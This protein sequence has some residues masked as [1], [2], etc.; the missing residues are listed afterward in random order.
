MKK[1]IFRTTALLLLLS[2]SIFAQ[3]KKVSFGLKGG[4]NYSNL[5]GGDNKPIVG[6]HVGGFTEIKLSNLISFQPELLFSAQGFKLETPI[7]ENFD[8]PITIRTYTINLN[9]VNIPLLAKFNITPV[10]NASFG[11]QVGVLIMAK[12]DDGGDI[13]NYYNTIDVAA[14]FGAGLTFSH[15]VVD[16]RYNLGL[17]DVQKNQ[18]PGT[19]NKSSVIQLSVGYKF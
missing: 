9:Y 10:F 4:V 2:N 12:N 1:V 18:L 17:T 5:N 19:G 15:F 6:F 7:R 8:D 3:D 13:I 14:D 11:P 16:A